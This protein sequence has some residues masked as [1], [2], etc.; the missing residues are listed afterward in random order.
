MPGMENVGAYNF[1]NRCGG[2]LGSITEI[3]ICHIA[4]F[5]H[6]ALNG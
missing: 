2:W 1:N 4:S 3:P 5:V 6:N